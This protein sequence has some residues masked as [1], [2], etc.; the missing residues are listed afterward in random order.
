LSGTGGTV[1]LGVSILTFGTS[2]STTYAG[3]VQGAGGLIK[4][5][6]GTF[7]LV[8]ANPYSGTTR[9]NDGEILLQNVASAGSGP[10]INS[11]GLGLNFSN[12]TFSNNLSSTGVTS[13]NGQNVRISGINNNFSGTWRINGTS[14]VA[15][16]I[17]LGTAI[18]SLPSNA[19]QLSLRPV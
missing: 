19:S 18:V 17:N 6:S 11:S 3:I 8:N 16:P 12:A 1:N 9:I 15:A 14:S 2:T 13:I 7:T 5:G 4:Q 10:L